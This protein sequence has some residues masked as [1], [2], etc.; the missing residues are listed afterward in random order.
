[1]NKSTN[2]LKFSQH[3]PA[4]LAATISVLGI[5]VW[6]EL[7]GWRILEPEL[8]FS[9]AWNKAFVYGVL[10]TS[11]GAALFGIATLLFGTT[12]P[13]TKS[14]ALSHAVLLWTFGAGIFLLVMAGL[15]NWAP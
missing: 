1:M 13:K 4:A 9:Q 5:S 2:T 6:I 14:W 11:A 3:L 10:R 7:L 8:F 15:V 12:L